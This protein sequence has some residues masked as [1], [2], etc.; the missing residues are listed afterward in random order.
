MAFE[1]PAMTKDQKI[2][3]WDLFFDMY[4]GNDKRIRF[5]RAARNHIKS[6]KVADMLLNGREIRNGRLF[7]VSFSS[8]INIGLSRSSSYTYRPA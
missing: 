1:Y 8:A 7:K 3:L 6:D 4:T 5:E 2:G